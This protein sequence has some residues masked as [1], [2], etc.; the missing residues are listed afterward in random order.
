VEGIHKKTTLQRLAE[1]MGALLVEA[2]WDSD[3]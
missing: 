1:V 3:E 2:A